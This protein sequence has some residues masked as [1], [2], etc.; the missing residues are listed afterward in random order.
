MSGGGVSSSIARFYSVP[1]ALATPDANANSIAFMLQASSPQ[2]VFAFVRAPTI[3]VAGEKTFTPSMLT[4]VKALL[5]AGGTGVGEMTLRHSGPPMLAA[6]I[7]ADQEIA[8]AVYAE[9]AA[10]GVPVSIHFETRDKSSPDVDIVSRIEELRAALS[11]NPGTRFIWCHL[12][13]TE[14]ATVLMPPSA[15]GPSGLWTGVLAVSMLVVGTV[16]WKRRT[17]PAPR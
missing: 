11:G 9:A 16:A 8:M 6:D 4:L 13:D 17:S 7:A 5:G 14:A 1:R 12:G 15:P 10:R 2:P 3:L